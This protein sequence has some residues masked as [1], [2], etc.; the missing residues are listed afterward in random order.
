MENNEPIDEETG[1]KRI[2]DN[3]E[4]IQDIP[5][6]YY[7]IIPE[8]DPLVYN[9]LPDLVFKID[10]GLDSMETIKNMWR[11]F[12]TIPTGK[13]KHASI[14]KQPKI[15]RSFANDNFNPEKLLL[16]DEK[17]TQG[18]NDLKI[19][20]EEYSKI[21][22]KGKYL[23]N[24]FQHITTNTNLNE[25]NKRNKLIEFINN[26]KTEFSKDLIEFSKI[27]IDFTYLNQLK[28]ELIKFL[29][30]RYEI[31]THQIVESFDLN[32]DNIELVI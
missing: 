21:N 6:K 17:Y 26:Y 25:T 30:L 2:M 31:I 24:S 28:L 27:K 23:L 8:S 7:D 18:K 9:N 22:L 11:R 13:A 4:D 15:D 29:K 3:F 19:L 12:S 16:I 20:K 14:K 1:L 5:P 32:I 10:S